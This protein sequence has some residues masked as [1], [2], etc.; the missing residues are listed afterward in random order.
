MNKNEPKIPFPPEPRPGWDEYFAGFAFVAATR[1]T[2]PRRAVGAV[3]VQDFRIIATGYN[4]APARLEHCPSNSP[5]GH[6]SC[7]EN[8]HCVRT[9]HAEMN[10]II[11][12]AAAGVSTTEATLYAT[13]CPC[14]RCMGAIVNAGI[15]QVKFV[16]PY[17]AESHRTDAM[18]AAFV[19]A[20]Q[21][22]ISVTKLHRTSRILGIH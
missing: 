6:A 22:K 5:E 10:A 20:E 8:G 14:P 18:R 12:C 1:S 7:M 21:A 11:A 15:R 17:E 3:I 19:I 16:E 2:C 4:G 13:T 9:I